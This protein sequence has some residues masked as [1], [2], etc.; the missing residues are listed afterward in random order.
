M[1]LLDT[2]VWVWWVTGEKRLSPD[3]ISEIQRNEAAMIGISVIS[4]WEVAM[5]AERGKVGFSLPTKEWIRTALMYPGFRL[6]NI[7]SDI[8]VDS[9]HL[10]GSFHK[11]P[12]DRIIVATA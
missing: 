5:L 12:A 3:Q 4:C 1:I 10:P 8:A 6:V 2:H 11:D 9:V 7:T